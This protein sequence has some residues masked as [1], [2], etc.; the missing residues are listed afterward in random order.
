MPERRPMLGQAESRLVLPRESFLRNV[1]GLASSRPHGAYSDSS[2]AV[3]SS[4]SSS[5]SLA[6]ATTSIS[7]FRDIPRK[8]RK[9]ASLSES[10]PL[11][12]V[13]RDR[14]SR[15]SE[16]IAQAVRLR[17]GKPSRLQID[18]LDKAHRELPHFRL[19]EVLGSVLHHIPQR[20][21]DEHRQSDLMRI[22]PGV[23]VRRI[24]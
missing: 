19:F 23:G 9:S 20:R 18:R 10:R 4:F 6:G 12:D 5:Q 21:S 2:R 13:Q 1:L 16:L 15:T 14:N 3:S 17:P 8:R 22:K 24:A 11:G 7:D